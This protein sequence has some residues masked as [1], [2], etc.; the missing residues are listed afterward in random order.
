MPTTLTAGAPPA[1]SAQ[2][3][4]A[5]LLAVAYF[6][7]ADP[8]LA[9]SRAR[10]SADLADHL[11]DAAAGRAVAPTVDVII[12]GN[13]T[14]V[15]HI[16]Q[17]HGAT[18]KK[19]LQT[20]AVLSVTTASLASLANDAEAGAVS[21]DGALRSQ[22][23]TATES[24]GAAAA[25]AGE[26]TKLGAVVGTGIGVA[27]IDSGIDAHT[28]LAGRVVVSADFTRAQLTFNSGDKYGHGTH[29]AGIVAAGVPAYDTGA[30]P[31]GMAPGAHL[32]NLKVLDENGQGKV[33]AASSTC[34]SGPRRRSRIRTTRCARRSSARRGPE[35]SSSRR[36]VITDRCRMAGAFSAP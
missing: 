28:A 27:I 36:R 1:G 2:W 6:S 34:R 18:I 32:I 29:V 8:V 20:G 26:I 7:A 33:S 15:Q 19:E 3:F 16:A 21:G 25:W 24:T 17:R 13:A 9:Q 11:L 35:W 30:E 22:L 14:F 31:V 12:T 4:F 5:A 10:L 23:A